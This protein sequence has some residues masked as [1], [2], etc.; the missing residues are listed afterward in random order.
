MHPEDTDPPYRT[1]ATALADESDSSSL[2]DALSMHELED[3]ETL[4]QIKQVTDPDLEG[5]G[6]HEEALQP[7]L[8]EG[9][10][11]DGEDTKL[12]CPHCGNS[13]PNDTGLNVSCCSLA[14]VTAANTDTCTAPSQR[15]EEQLLEEAR[16]RLSSRE[17]VLPALQDCPIQ[18]VI[19]RGMSD[20]GEHALECP[21]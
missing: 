3:V 19:R 21:S 8:A 12:D 13:F 5:N 15:Q 2:S 17:V 16:R 20:T 4:R 7:T 6:G 11:S 10:G 14:Y 18:E 1:V 9:A